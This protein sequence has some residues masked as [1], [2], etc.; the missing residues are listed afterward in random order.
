MFDRSAPDPPDPDEL[1]EQ[2]ARALMVMRD[3][4]TPLFE[5]ADGL[6]ADLEKRGWSP[7]AAEAAVLPWLQTMMALCAGRHPTT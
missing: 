5:A 6:R 2:F 7:T 3:Q 1:R 4:M